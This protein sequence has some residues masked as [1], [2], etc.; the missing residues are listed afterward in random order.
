MIQRPIRAS[1][2]KPAR[3]EAEIVAMLDRKLYVKFL[4]NPEGC[5][6]SV[7]VYDSFEDSAVSLLFGLHELSEL[8]VLH[9]PPSLPGELTEKGLLLLARH[10]RLQSFSLQNARIT[11]AILGAIAEM[12]SLQWLQLTSCGLV[13][14][15]LPVLVGNAGL[16]GLGLNWNPISDSGMRHVLPLTKLQWLSLIGT[17]VSS[18]GAS[19]FM[20]KRRSCRVI[21]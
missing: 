7:F 13:D 6:F 5:V 21:L 15:Q 18:D 16:L 10:L 8:H 17:H 2:F 12:T 3:H 4:T 20:E 11:T 1:D 9:F 14:E 19:A